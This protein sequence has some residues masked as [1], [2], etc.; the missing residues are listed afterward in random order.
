MVPT[1]Q[2]VVAVAMFVVSYTLDRSAYDCFYLTVARTFDA[3]LLTA[4][5][6]LAEALRST[7]FASHIRRIGG[8]P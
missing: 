5:A 2:V 4:D 1:V 6:K 3:P 8:G 7:P